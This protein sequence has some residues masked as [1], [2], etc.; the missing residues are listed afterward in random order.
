MELH[1]NILTVNIWRQVKNFQLLR[2]L[3]MFNVFT[4]FFL[5][6]VKVLKFTILKT[7]NQRK[8]HNKMSNQIL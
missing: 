6:R 8:T 7:Q 5:T 1:K 4:R 2:I 3:E